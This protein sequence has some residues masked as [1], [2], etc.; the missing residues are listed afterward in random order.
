VSTVRATA[1]K[2]EDV[3]FVLFND[4]VYAAFERAMG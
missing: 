4:E 1:T 2:V 3:R